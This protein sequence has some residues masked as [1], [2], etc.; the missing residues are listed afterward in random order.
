M[1]DKLVLL[2]F[3]HSVARIAAR[4]LR[5]QRIC[6]KIFPGDTSAETVLAEDPCGLLLCASHDSVFSDQEGLL[7]NSRVPVLALGSAAAGMAVYLGGSAGALIEDRRLV[8]IR[9]SECPLHEGMHSS[10]RMISGLIPLALPKEVSVIASVEDSGLPFTFSRGDIKRFGT[11]LE[12]EVHDPDCVTLLTNF[13][14]RICGCTA[15]WDED[16]FV[17]QKVGEIRR[18]AG[19]GTALC[20]MTGGLHSSVSALLGARAL[21]ERMI[22]VF[23]NTGLL[24][25]GEADTFERFFAGRIHLPLTF[26]DES[27]RFLQALR[28]IRD[29]EEKRYA[30]HSLMNVISREIQ[31]QVPDL[32]LIIHDRTFAEQ[33][34]EDYHSLRTGVSLLEPLEDLFLDEVRQIGSYLG[35]PYDMIAGQ[36]IPDTGLALNIVGEVTE[37]KLSVLRKAD[38]IFR[39]QLRQ[40]GQSKK[41]SEYYAVLRPYEKDTYSVVLRA[42]GFHQDDCLRAARM[43]YDVLEESADRIRGECPQVKRVLYDLTPTSRQ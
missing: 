29:Q 34:H 20:V 22:G 28:G 30:V 35:L 40:S 32:S 24:Q 11:L 43:P 9:W 4:M 18:A 31:R 19:D 13:A 17:S 2:D 41:L 14:L 15:W 39:N 8:S 12:L 10:R 36:I 16:A 27:G 7:L 38:A 3:D 6:C 25:E 26:L 23:L 42:L 5:S 1:R 37:E 33:P 21:N